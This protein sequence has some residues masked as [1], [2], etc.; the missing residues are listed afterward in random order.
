[1]TNPDIYIGRD[2]ENYPE[3]GWYRLV[4][5]KEHPDHG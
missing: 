2:E 3:E 1:M 4:P 5:A